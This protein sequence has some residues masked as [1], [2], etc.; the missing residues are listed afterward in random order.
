MLLLL[1]LFAVLQAAD[2]VLTYIGLKRGMGEMNPVA[3]RIIAALGMIPAIV[4]FKLGGIGLVGGIAY[5]AGEHWP[6][7]MIPACIVALYPIYHNVK[8][9]RS[10]K[11]K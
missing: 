10:T 8:A 3:R 5:A 2:G 1:I 9:I 11:E 4:A 7:V 6:W